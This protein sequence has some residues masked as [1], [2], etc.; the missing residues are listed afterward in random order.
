LNFLSITNDAP[1]EFPLG[2]TIV[3]WTAIDQSGNSAT[4]TQKVTIVDTTAPTIQIPND[5]EI[6]ASSPDSNIVSL[7][8]ASANDNVDVTTITNDSPSVFPVGETIVTWTATDAAGNVSTASQIV[9][10]VDTTKPLVLSPDDITIEASDPLQ[11]F[12][13][14]GDASASDVGG[15]VTISNDAPSAFSFGETL[16]TWTATDPSGNSATDIQTITVVDTTS[17]TINAPE[18]VTIEAISLTNNILDIGTAVAKDIMGI[19]SI[20]NDAPGAFPFGETIVTWTATDPSGNSAISKQKVTVI[21]TTGPQL[22]IPDD[23]A[24]DATSL[25]TIVTIGKATATDI[26][27][28][29]PLI[30]NNAPITFPLG[31]TIVTWTATDQFGNSENMTQIITVQACG[32][33]SS[34]FNLIIGGQIDDVLTGTNLADLIFGLEGNDIISG[35]GGDDCIGGGGGDDIIFGNDGVDKIAGDDGND[36]IRGGSGEDGINGNSGF[37]IIDG[38]DEHDSCNVGEINS[39]DVVIKCETGKL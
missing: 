4:G 16:V 26:I 2:E 3:T 29:D 20:S 31:E 25:E 6:E 5:V 34:S 36:I 32:K 38:G 24:I 13:I 10:I 14:L 35:E 7:G 12:A 9:K 18:N 33:P 1:S 27:D 39:D 8:D 23:V 30:T 11:N 19:D 17:P 21:D 37:D 28:S 22:I 15:I